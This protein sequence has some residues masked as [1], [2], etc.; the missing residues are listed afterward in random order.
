MKFKTAGEK[1]AFR[2]G[3][4]VGSSKRIN[5]KKQK[6]KQKINLYLYGLC[7]RYAHHMGRKYG[8]N[9]SEILRNIDV[10]YKQALI[11]PKFYDDLKREYDS[12][13]R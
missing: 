13:H 12:N 5:K 9:E 4:S 2:I 7:D 6:N 3:L 1:K 10:H 8:L 11:D